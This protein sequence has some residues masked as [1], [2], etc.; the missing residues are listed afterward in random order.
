MLACQACAKSDISLLKFLLECGADPILQDVE[1]KDSFD[2]CPF[3]GEYVKAL[4]REKAG[5]FISI[6]YHSCP[7][8][9][10]V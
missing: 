8:Q 4:M 7:P 1:G 6:F 10:W 5:R 3:D 2:Y 9:E